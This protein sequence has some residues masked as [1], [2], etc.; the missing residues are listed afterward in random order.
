MPW[1]GDTERL[2]HPQGHLRTALLERPASSARG[3]VF[4]LQGRGEFLEKYRETAAWL[5]DQGF[6]V[7]G[8][9]WRGQGGS[10]RIIEG[11]G[12]GHVDD[13]AH[14]LDDLDRLAARAEA[15][16]LPRPWQFLGHSLGGHLALRW[17]GERDGPVDRLV[18]VTPMLG[19][20]FRP[21]PDRL[22]RALVRSAMALGMAER[23]APGQRDPGPQV[24]RF[25]GN[26]L[27]SCPERFA[28]WRELTTAHS[29]LTIGGVT[30][31]WLDAA[32]RSIDLTRRPELL[33]RVRAPT[34][35]LLAEGEGVV[36]NAAIEEFATRLPR[37]EL[38]RLPDALHD[39]LWE[40]RATIAAVRRA[41][42]AHLLATG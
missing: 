10:A 2:I 8:L 3:T 18:L 20:Q 1:G 34:L 23:Y 40:R 25:E 4:V 42:T 7:I 26:R 24:C 32:L 11:S 13:F 15:L 36:S 6:S 37:A 12:R 5:H 21:L 19:L 41:I 22:A 39:L 38:F 16:R 27:T 9:D 17:I 31:G 14:Y 29:E 35:L 30:W 33:A 28:A